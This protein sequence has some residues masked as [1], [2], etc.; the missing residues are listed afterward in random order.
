MNPSIILL[1]F[2]TNANHFEKICFLIDT[3]YFSGY[4]SPTHYPLG[5]FGKNEIFC[6]VIPRIAG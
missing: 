1:H 4:I 3:K 6:F 2:L 5:Y